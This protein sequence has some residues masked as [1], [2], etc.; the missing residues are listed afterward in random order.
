MKIR[1]VEKNDLEVLCQMIYELAEYE[2]IAHRC[3]VTVRELET[4]FF[5]P[6]EG[7][8]RAYLFEDGINVVGYMIT[9]YNY[10]TFHGRKGLYLE[11]LYVR[12]EFR[13]KGF[14]KKGL[15]YLADLA[16]REGCTRLEW[17]V[18][19]W[20]TPAIDFYKSLNAEPQSEWTVFRL[21]GPTLL[22]VAELNK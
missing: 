7:S 9:F 10:S 17:S 15:T 5:T 11:D 16:V 4:S 3:R 22:S 21:M 18:L 12:P 8:P 20:N 14:G 2:K 6:D 13:G 1:L 19:N